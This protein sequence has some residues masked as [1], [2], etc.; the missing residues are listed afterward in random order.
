MFSLN[1]EL[2]MLNTNLSMC[3]SHNFMHLIPLP[4][5]IKLLVTAKIV[6]YSY[7]SLILYGDT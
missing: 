4:T 3:L 6:F 1:K 5:N 2:T 7:A